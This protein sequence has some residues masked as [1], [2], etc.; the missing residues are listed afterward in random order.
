MPTPFRRRLAI[1]ATQSAPYLERALA[2]DGNAPKLAQVCRREIAPRVQ[3]AAVVPDHEIAD[4]PAVLVLEFGPLLM[5]EY[6][7]EQR[8]ALFARQADD[9]LGHQAIDVERLAPGGRMGA[10]HRMREAMRRG[11]GRRTQAHLH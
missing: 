7:Q 3:R 4:L 9:R 6:A 1:A 10:D 11:R 5:L 2:P 8:V